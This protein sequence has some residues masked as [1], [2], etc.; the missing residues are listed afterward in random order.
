MIPPVT[1]AHV[2]M[3]DGRACVNAAR[4]R[5]CAV[6]ALFVLDG[7][8]PADVAT[9]TASGFR[10]AWSG[11][12]RLQTRKEKFDRKPAHAIFSR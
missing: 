7:R 8:G 11:V 10:R 2:I 12:R 5:Q 6:A 1:A 3:A 4:G 9:V